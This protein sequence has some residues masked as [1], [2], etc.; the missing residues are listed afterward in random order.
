MSIEFEKKLKAFFESR[1]DFVVRSCASKGPADL[2]RFGRDGVTEILQLKETK[3]P[4]L[5]I[6]SQEAKELHRLEEVFRVNTSFFIRFPHCTVRC[7]MKNLGESDVLQVSEDSKEC[8]KI[9]MKDD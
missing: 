6:S 7:P 4:I 9:E 2:V 8:E 5:K 1:G 3:T